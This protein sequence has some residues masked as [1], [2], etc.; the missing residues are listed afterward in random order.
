MIH[1]MKKLICSLLFLLIFWHPAKAD[2]ITGGEMFYT[3]TGMTGLNYNYS[4]TTKFFKDCL[5]N[6]QLN[7]VVTMIV[8]DKVSNKEVMRVDA[9][10]AH[11]ET[12]QMTN[13]N[14]CITDPPP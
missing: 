12:L 3:Y 9:P 5:S 4:V 13:T 8:F 1:C 2:H 7:N 11:T 6:R 10:L 14:K